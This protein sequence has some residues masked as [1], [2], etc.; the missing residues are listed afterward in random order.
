MP[1]AEAGTVC[2]RVRRNRP[3]A[4]DASDPALWALDDLCAGSL[5]DRRVNT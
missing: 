1:L 5:L 2:L 4:R 3:D